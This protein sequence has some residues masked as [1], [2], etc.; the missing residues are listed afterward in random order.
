VTLIGDVTLIG[1]T[2]I[3]LRNKKLFCPGNVS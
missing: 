2:L 1:V 3:S